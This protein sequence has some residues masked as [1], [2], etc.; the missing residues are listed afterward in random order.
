MDMFDVKRRD[1]PDFNKFLDI[2][3]ESSEYIK[4]KPFRDASGKQLPKDKLK[5]Y[6]N[7]I[8]RDPTFSNNVYDPTY[9]AMT[10]DVV[11]KQ[12]TDKEPF[13]YKTHP[14]HVPGIAVTNVNNEGKAITVF[15]DY[16][17]EMK[18]AELEGEEKSH[19]EFSKQVEEERE[20][21]EKRK[22]EYLVEKAKSKSQQRLMGQA[23]AY[24]K[25][26]LKAKDMDPKFKD[27]IVGLSQDMTE[28][29]LKAFAKTKHKGLP[30][31]K[32]K[33]AN[34]NFSNFMREQIDYALM[35]VTDIYHDAMLELQALQNEFVSTP[36]D[37]T[38][39]RDALKEKIIAKN[40]EVKEKEREFEEVLKATSPE[41]DEKFDY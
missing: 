7:E 8:E 1:I 32:K 33:K 22:L 29:E 12:S 35:K 14:E 20:K 5:G 2:K 23:Y 38:K 28:K 17:T 39:E 4:K 40:R 13:D 6:Q 16:L 37:N 30:E 36:K 24:R 27:I 31:K 11:Y 21:G 15:D 34:E 18:K 3:V 26:T 41:F 9:R 10:H 19:V 25:G